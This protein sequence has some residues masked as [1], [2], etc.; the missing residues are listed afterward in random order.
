MKKIVTIGAAGHLGREITRQ[1]EAQSGIEQSC[2]DIS[3]IP[4][5]RGHFFTKKCP[6]FMPGKL[7]I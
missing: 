7:L 4:Y 6:F 5:S 2:F 3:S 1:L